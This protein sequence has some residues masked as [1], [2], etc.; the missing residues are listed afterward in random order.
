MARVDYTPVP[1]VQARDTAPDDLQ[2]VQAS[3]DAFGASLDQGMA[4]AG[5]GLVKATDFYGD[6]ASTQAVNNAITQATNVLRGDSSKTVVRP[7][8]QTVPDTGYFGLRGANAMLARE[9]TSKSIQSIIAQNGQ[10]LGTPEAQLKYE[11]TIR[12]FQSEW[13]NQIGSHAD[14]QQQ[15]WA[16]YVNNT[17]AALAINQVAASAGDDLAVA[18]AQ[19]R[20]RDAF[21]KN[22][23]LTYGNSEDIAQGAV[24]KADQA[25]T[26][27]RID[28]LVISDPSKA[29]QI[30]DDSHG[31]L[32]SLPDYD[33]IGQKVRAANINATMGPAVD[34]AVADFTTSASKAVGPIGSG[35]APLDMSGVPFAQAKARIISGEGPAM[36]GG[37]N[38]QVYNTRGGGN[39]VGL[40]PQ[41][42]TGMTLGQ[43]EDYQT[44]VIRPATR[45]H[46]GE[47]DPGTTAVGAYQF[48]AATLAHNAQ[49]VFGPNWKD[50]P[51]SPE[52]QDRIAE[53]LY[54]SV[55]NDPAALKAQWPSLHGSQQSYPSSTQSMVAQIPNALDA[56]K[57]KAGSLFPN[58]P[59]A[60][61]NFVEN[62]HNKLNEQVK[63]QSE[64]TGVNASVIQSVVDSDHPPLS[65]QDLVARGPDVAAAWAYMQKNEPAAARNIRNSFAAN[66]SGAAGN[67]G[68]DFKSYLDR[69]LAPADDPNR[70]AHPG[71]LWQFIGPNDAAP[72]TN[73]GA[74]E[75]AALMPNRGTPQAE[76]NAALMRSFVDN[77]HANLTFTNK[78]TGIVDAKGEKKFAQYMAGVLPVLANAQKQGN[79]SDMLNPQSKNYI[80]AGAQAFTRSQTE[81]MKDRLSAQT[82][83]QMPAYTRQ[84]LSQALDGLDNDAQRKEA[85]KAAV[86]QK[87]ISIQDATTLGVARG[88]ISKPPNSIEATMAT[89]D[90]IDKAFPAGGPQAGH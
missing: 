64:Q 49:A 24:L 62:V 72:L 51:F 76:A 23:Q 9:G 32:G 53:H 8:G 34:Q 58:D 68:S 89:E 86:T 87:R 47:S 7:D 5:Q 71:Q 31:L 88:Y 43:V 22:A 18:A 79:L 46:R 48:E 11:G 6:V 82:Q 52:N 40:K 14:Q 15:A 67:L 1:G 45:G 13:E 38:A 90:A 41:N 10:T 54:N 73:S 26:R 4:Q 55:H 78:A 56:A 21:V 19:H 69:T 37:Y 85:L 16:T 59:A 83:A 70:L 39:A 65:E 75:L 25:V 61:E 74:K 17:Q 63:L 20:V 3:P 57:I 36:I 44:H 50:Q 29:K 30:F 42:L 27:A 28:A 66:A 60:Q 35:G 80:G 2:H 84:S 33:G 12:R 77:M 81:I